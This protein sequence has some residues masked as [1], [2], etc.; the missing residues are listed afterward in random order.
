MSDLEKFT[1]PLPEEPGLLGIT[2]LKGVVDALGKQLAPVFDE[3]RTTWEREGPAA[4][5]A[6]DATGATLNCIGGNCPVQAE[7][8]VDGRPF[9]FRARGDEW[10]LDI[11]PEDQWHGYGCWRIE[12]DYGSGFDAGWMHKHEALGFIVEGIAEYRARLTPSP[13]KD[14]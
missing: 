9:Y 14:S 13:S 7:G 10:S 2:N 8:I 4:Q 6:F 1:K 12:R 5:A 3:Q 11:G